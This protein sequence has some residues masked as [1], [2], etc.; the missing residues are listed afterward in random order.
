MTYKL[1]RT[2]IIC[3]SLAVVSVISFLFLSSNAVGKKPFDPEEMSDR[4]N[5]TNETCNTIELE[6]EEKQGR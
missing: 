1:F 3:T 6:V 5:D 2:P 4:R